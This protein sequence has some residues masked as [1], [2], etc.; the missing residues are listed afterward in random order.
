MEHMWQLQTDH[1]L[2]LVVTVAQNPNLQYVVASFS[3]VEGV[4]FI[5]IE[6]LP[7]FMALLLYFPNYCMYNNDLPLMW[8]LSQGL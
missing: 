4:L 7:R 8:L 2:I 3:P 5:Y 1:L 6:I